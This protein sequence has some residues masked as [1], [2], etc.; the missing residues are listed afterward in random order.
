MV[1]PS[2]NSNRFSA[3]DEAVDYKAGDEFKAVEIRHTQN[4]AEHLPGLLPQHL[5]DLRKS[6]LTDATIKAAGIVSEFSLMKVKALLDTKQFAQRCLPVLVFPYKDAE[7]RNGYCR[8]KPDHPRTSGGKL[9]KYESPRGQ[10]NQIYIPPGVADVLPDATRELLIIEGEKKALAGNQAGFATIGLVGV[11]GYK[12]KG[13]VTLL[14][15]LERIAWNGRPVFIVF[16]SDIATNPDVQAAESQ[17][18]ALVK[19]R[20]AVVRVVRLPEGETG[21]DGKPV[22]VGLDDFL[23]ACQ[24]RGLNLAGEMRKLLDAA[25]EPEKPVGGTIKRAATEIDPVPKAAAFLGT[26]EKDGV[27]RLRYWRGTWLYWRQGAYLELPP[28]EVPR[29]ACRLS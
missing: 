9:V 24:A 19:S 12:P 1:F 18:A 28:S 20:G 14:P 4:V 11:N 25:E 15:A 16:D 29:P 8:I 26:T 6:G 27:P 2:D 17:L 5:A 7:G 13:K 21:P 22:K 3:V 10:P 23:V